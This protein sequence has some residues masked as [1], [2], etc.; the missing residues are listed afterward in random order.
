MEEV[1]VSII[2]ITY[3]HEK[4]IQ[5]C[6]DGFIAQKT[7]FKFEVL[8]H[9]DASTDGTVK[10]IQSYQTKYPD[11][12]K[13][14]CEEENQYSKGKY[15]I[16]KSLFPHVRGKYVAYCE[17]DDFWCDQNKLQRQ[18]DILES[19]LNCTI[20]VHRTQKVDVNG[21]EL[22]AIIE[23][24]QI[25]PGIVNGAKFLEFFLQ[26]TGMPFQT[27][28]FFMRSNLVLEDRAAFEDVFHVS[29][30]PT[31]LWVS[32]VGDLYYDYPV[33][34]CYRV[35]TP[36]STNDLMKEKKYAIDKIHANI[37]GYKAFDKATD[38]KYWKYMK[39][40]VAYY[41]YQYYYATKDSAYKTELKELKKEL[42]MPE[43]IKA[44]VKYTRFGNFLRNKKACIKL[45]KK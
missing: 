43:K 32:A 20:S 18:F 24:G 10:I 22:H 21:N 19:N 6:L 38:H 36:G 39:H 11:V 37:E 30:V 42:S 4:Y 45:L 5:K 28:S 14:F 3:N 25:E 2:C 9:D 15:Q 1:L 13:L 16:D 12:I 23:P 33:M 41:V 44:R 7:N 27:S 8:V 29:D 17:G 31:L 34:S 26:G 40:R 35:A